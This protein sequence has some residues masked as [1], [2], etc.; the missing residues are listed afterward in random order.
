MIRMVQVN[1]KAVGFCKYSLALLFWLS[2]LFQSF[3]PLLVALILLVM[4][5]M[6]GV[7]KAPLVWLYHR[8]LK[9][10][11]KNEYINFHSMRFAHVVA[12]IFAAISL[13]LF[14]ARWMIAFDIVVVGVAF[15]QTAASFGYCSAQKLYE[16]VVCNQNCCNLGNR[17]K[18]KKHD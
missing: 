11:P 12:A 16:C 14:F 17:I 2:V 10:A 3:W 15:L 7:D 4:S 5:A 18:G 1:K 13:L 6:V 9:K 8:I